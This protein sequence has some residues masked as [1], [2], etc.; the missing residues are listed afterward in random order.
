MTLPGNKYPFE[1]PFDAIHKLSEHPYQFSTP[2]KPPQFGLNLKAMHNPTTPD[3]FPYHSVHVLFPPDRPH[4]KLAMIFLR[5][6]YYYRVLHGAFKG[7]K[8]FVESDVP[9]TYREEE[10]LVLQQLEHLVHQGFVKFRDHLLVT[11]APYHDGPQLGRSSIADDVKRALV[12][13]RP[14]IGQND[15]FDIMRNEAVEMSMDG[16]FKTSDEKSEEHPMSFSTDAPM[17]HKAPSLEPTTPAF[18]N[19]SHQRGYPDPLPRPTSPV[20]FA[21]P[22]ARIP[23]RGT[24]PLETIAEGKKLEVVEEKVSDEPEVKFVKEVV[25]VKSDGAK[26]VVR[27][28]RVAKR[29][30]ESRGDA[31]YFLLGG[32]LLG[33]AWMLIDD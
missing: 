6:Y 23:Q 5:W 29:E 10:W 13:L 2:Q 18:T 14:Y 9:A 21:N 24:K 1:G 33:L 32:V 20:E 30:E 22:A 31:Y 19:R 17:P 26:V 11:T 7:K 28:T 16:D 3:Y 8:N 27:E 12:V 25:M 4:W 15:G